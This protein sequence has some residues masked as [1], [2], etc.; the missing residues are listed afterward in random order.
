MSFNI[1]KFKSEGLVYGG[2]RP[3][4]FKVA[5]QVP[6]GIGIDSV[7]VRKFEFVC[8]T[9]ELPEVAVS[10]FDVPYFG[11]KIKL[12][13]DRNFN[14]WQVNIMNDE[15]FAVRS[16]FETWSNALN[17]H[18]SNV[19]DP[20]ISEEL[21]KVDLEVTQFS[22]DGEKIRS[23]LIVGAFPNSIGEIGLSWDQANAIENFNV[24][25]VQ[26]AVDG[27]HCTSAHAIKC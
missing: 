17:R 3:S 27:H 6:T 23:Y 20:A 11:R 10:S 13:G 7:S 5:L 22:K 18:V 25:F 21:Y 19:R 15:D 12:A 9:A 8:R 26:I 14:D 16:L 2:A 4:L 1:N 24:T